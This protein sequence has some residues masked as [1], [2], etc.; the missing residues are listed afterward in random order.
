[1]VNVRWTPEDKRPNDADSWQKA[2]DQTY[3][4]P[5]AGEVE[6]VYEGKCWRVETAT[7]PAGGPYKPGDQFKP[8]SHDMKEKVKAAL[9]AAGL[10]VC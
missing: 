9:R 1:M 6:L 5:A 2:I 7:K 8:L 4:P 3:G 10:P